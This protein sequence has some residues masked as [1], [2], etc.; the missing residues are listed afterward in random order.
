MKL[1]KLNLIAC[2]ALLLATLPLSSC[3]KDNKAANEADSTSITGTW[4]TA[5][6]M[7]KDVSS[8]TKTAASVSLV[9]AMVD[10]LIDSK[11]TENVEGAKKFAKEAISTSIEFAQGIKL[12]LKDG[13]ACNV[14]FAGLTAGIDGTWKEQDGKI[15]LKLHEVPQATLEQLK[16]NTGIKEKVN[17]SFAA[18]ISGKELSLTKTDSSTIKWELDTQ[19]LMNAIS[20]AA[21]NQKVSLVGELLGQ[22]LNKASYSVEFT[23]A[24]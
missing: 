8:V 3:K 19:F 2:A 18:S 22:Y 15:I 24:K 7:G 4:T 5:K 10:Q 21:S 20:E 14:S 16:A 17:S 12:V 1:A 23:K 13:N 11:I 9:T 6:V